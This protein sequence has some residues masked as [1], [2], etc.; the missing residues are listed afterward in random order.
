MKFVTFCNSL[1]NVHW[2]WVNLWVESWDE[3]Y[4]LLSA[5][6]DLFHTLIQQN[7]ESFRHLYLILMCTYSCNVVTVFN[8]QLH[9]PKLR[10]SGGPGQ[11]ESK[12][13]QWLLLRQ[14]QSH[15][16][17][18][19]LLRASHGTILAH[20]LYLL[21]VWQHHWPHRLGWLGWRDLQG[22]VSSEPFTSRLIAYLKHAEFGLS[23][24]PY[25]HVLTGHKVEWSF[26]W[27]KREG[28]VILLVVSAGAPVYSAHFTIY[29]SWFII[30]AIVVWMSTLID[31]LKWNENGNLIIT[32]SYCLI[33]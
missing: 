29:S 31:G 5:W 12:W 3:T 20:H 8:I 4:N 2:Q 10:G 15:W 33:L 17:R 28:P 14:L 1:H 26:T 19:H 23:I 16:H 7:C 21:L 25:K 24:K 18:E 32:A 30:F 9:R 27:T 6:M 11:A 22:R 13:P